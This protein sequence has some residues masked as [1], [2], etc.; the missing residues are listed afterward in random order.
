MKNKNQNLYKNLIT[1]ILMVILALTFLF[2]SVFVWFTLQKHADIGD[3]EVNV[4]SEYI[5]EITVNTYAISEITG[6]ELQ[7]D[8]QLASIEGSL[9]PLENIP[10]YDPLGITI[11]EYKD[12]I[13]INLNFFVT[14]DDI[15]FA[16]VASASSDFVTTTTNWLSNCTQIVSTNYNNTTLT[17][18]SFGLRY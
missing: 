5:V 9:V 7:K 1:S 11:N 6:D 17:L 16:I 18:S 12:C 4:Q 2:C 8:Y 15:N 14:V 13:A 10:I 3:F